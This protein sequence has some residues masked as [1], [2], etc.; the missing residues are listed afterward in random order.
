MRKSFLSI[1]ILFLS[2]S[3]VYGQI[4]TG[5]LP[6]SFSYNM[7]TEAERYNLNVQFTKLGDNTRTK[8]VDNDTILI[9]DPVK[10]L[11]DVAPAAE[12]EAE[13]IN[14]SEMNALLLKKVEELTLYVIKQ[15]EMLEEL[16]NEIEE[17]KK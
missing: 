10:H 12:M 1:A 8:I 7:R 5:E 13:G 14:V 11:P 4:S 16:K 17:L 3:A 15:Q 6:V 2:Y 9:S